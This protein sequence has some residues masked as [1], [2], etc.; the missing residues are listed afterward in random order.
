MNNTNNKGRIL[1]LRQFMFENTDDEHSVSTDNMIRLYEEHGYKANRHTIK[2]DIDVLNGYGVEIIGERQGNGKAYHIGT[3]LFELAELK[4]L[5]DAVSSSQFI[6]KAKS[7]TLIE[8]LGQLTNAQNR[9]SLAAKIFTADQIKTT[10]PRVFQTVDTVCRAID[11]G[12]KISFHYITY[13]PDKQRVLR[14]EGRQY[15]VSP[16]ALIWN[17][18]RYYLAAQYKKEG[19]VITFRIDRFHDVEILEEDAVIDEN[20]NPSDYASKTILMYDAGLQEQQVVLSCENRLMQN[21]VDKFGED[22]ATDVIDESHF[23]AKVLVRPSRTFYSWVFGFCGGI[24]IKSPQAVRIEYEAL[25]ED[26]LRSQKDST[27]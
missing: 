14:E 13:T 27:D 25:L 4:M 10:N 21:V 1:F 12:K 9:P 8:K 18:D 15:I 2:D 16:Y 24:R 19:S 26:V 6:T 23:V 11:A 3:R 22:I 20:F 7:D 5:V 17:D